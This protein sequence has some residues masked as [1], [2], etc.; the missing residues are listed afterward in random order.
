MP[1][2]SPVAP[3]PPRTFHAVVGYENSY[4]FMKPALYLLWPSVEPSTLLGHVFSRAE[5]PLEN[6]LC[7]LMFFPICL[8]FSDRMPG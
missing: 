8:R 6:W 7:I 1:R 2:W 5:Y 4:L 3:V